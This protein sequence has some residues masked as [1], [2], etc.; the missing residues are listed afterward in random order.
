MQD[1]VICVARTDRDLVLLGWTD[2]V[3]LEAVSPEIL[4]KE[5]L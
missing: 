1:T 3:D 5:I 2:V 4:E